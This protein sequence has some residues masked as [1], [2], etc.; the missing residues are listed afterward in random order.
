MSNP[1]FPFFP[2]DHLNDL[3]VRGSH[4]AAQGIWWSMVCFMAQ[5]S[6]FGFLKLAPGSPPPGPPPATASGV[7]G[8]IP[9]GVPPARPRVR[10]HGVPGGVTKPAYNLPASGSLEPELP[11]LLGLPED[12]VRWAIAHLESRHVFSR[13]PAGV[14]YCR[15]MKR[16]AEER[17]ARA[18][19]GREAYE[20]ARKKRGNGT[21]ATAPGGSRAPA[22]APPPGTPPGIPPG[23]P[24]AIA[25]VPVRG[26][27]GGPPN[28]NTKDK[29]DHPPLPPLRKRSGGSTDAAVQMMRARSKNT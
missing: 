8:G 5:G 17:E 4:P 24:P 12:L 23:T 11:Q 22:S 29:K 2:S 26:I 16:W 7:P 18:R 1:Y 10:E 20:R 13:D 14:I 25:P 28:T 19:R 9:R 21:P 6:P 15:R 3:G 27:S